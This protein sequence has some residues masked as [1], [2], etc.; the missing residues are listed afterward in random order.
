M[1]TNSRPTQVQRVLEYMK[2]HKYITQK[3]ADRDL[4]VSRLGARIFELKNK[5][6]IAVDSDFITVKNRFGEKC[7]VKRYWLADAS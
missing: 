4:G 3:D 6:G 5:H 2:N 7:D 1:E